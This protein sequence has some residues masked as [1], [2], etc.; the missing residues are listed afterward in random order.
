MRKWM[1]AL[2]VA[3][4]GAGVLGATASADEGCAR[5]EQLERENVYGRFDRDNFDRGNF[6]RA[7]FDRFNRDRFD[8]RARA[9]YAR[10]YRFDR[11]YDRF[12]GW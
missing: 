3:L 5:G 6:E 9:R 8:W 12:G 11:R 4:V 7:R 2:L 1:M 10:R